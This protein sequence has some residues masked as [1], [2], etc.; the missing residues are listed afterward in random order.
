MKN[1]AL[2]PKAVTNQVKPVAKKCQHDWMTFADPAF[3]KLGSIILGII[4]FL[5]NGITTRGLCTS[6]GLCRILKINF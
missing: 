6:Q 3:D 5:S 1:I 4:H 2:V